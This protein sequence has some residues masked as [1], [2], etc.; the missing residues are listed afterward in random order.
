MSHEVDYAT[1]LED[2]EARKATLQ[3]AIDSIKALM[4]QGA[5]EAITANKSSSGETRNPDDV[6]PGAFH[7]MSIAQAAKKYLGIVRTKQS[8][9]DIAAAIRKGGI[10]T[11]AKNFYSNLYSILQRDRDFLKLGTM[12]ALS[13]WHPTRPAHTPKGRKKK[14]KRG[15]AS[16][17]SSGPKLL[18]AAS[19]PVLAAGGGN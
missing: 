11:V 3:A 19:E 1:V 7:G 18:K 15:K 14:G 17:Q 4:G 8:T 16:P 12:W 13:E 10:E 2:L 5:L 9:G 6:G